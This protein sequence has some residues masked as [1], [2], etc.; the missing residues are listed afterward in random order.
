MLLLALFLLA[1]MDAISK[2]LTET[3]AVPQILAVRFWVFLTF[4]MILAGG[5]GFVRTARS[6]KSRIQVLRGLVMVGQMSAF[7]VAVRVMP[8]A[9]VHAI[10]A[11]APMLVMVLA[12]V[13]LSERIGPRRIAAVAVSFIGVLIIVRPG[14][15]VFE[16]ASLIA[17]GGAGCWAV[18]QILLRVV[19]RTDSAE[20]TTL[21]SAMAGFVCFSAAAPFVWQ[22][23]APE[24][25]AWL[26]AL[27]LLGACG[28]FLLSTAYRHAPASTLQPFAYSMPVWAALI[29]WAAF[30]HIPDGWT[31]TG[32]GIVVASGLYALR[33][34]RIA[35]APGP[36]G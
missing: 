2:H 34:E 11:A 13:F 32:G 19:G 20:T 5:S 4:A 1:C 27:G 3:L 21:Y 15:T 29:G 33:R 25:W 22:A 14:T 16:P 36:G 35:K 10:F 12:A 9:D 7:I 28:H 30:S 6:A 23:P 31:L 17:L 8:L 26:I 24:A 18:F